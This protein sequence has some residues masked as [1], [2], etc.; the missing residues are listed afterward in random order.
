MDFNLLY[1]KNKEQGI[2]R[3]F[4]HNETPS[5]KIIDISEAKNLPLQGFIFSEELKNDEFLVGLE[6]ELKF[7]PIRSSAE[8][9]LSAERFD[10]LSYDEAKPIF[11]KMREN[12]I[13][14]NNISLIEELFKVR[15]HLLGLFPNDRSGFFEELWFILK[16][17]LGATNLK[18]IYNDM[19]KAKNENEKNK[20]VKVKIVGERFPEMTSI[21]DMDE[22]VLKSYEKDFGNIFEITDYNKDKGQLVICASIKKSP[23]LIMTNIYQ[24]TRLQKAIL[25][26][27]FEGLNS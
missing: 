3:S 13:L 25:T 22:M 2:V 12:W 17:N 8:F 18:L 14:Q 24:L 16:S 19:I 23:V 4:K 1:T 21:D 5:S 15:T 20:L 10:K 6:N 26:S 7:Y 27:L 11:D 9:S